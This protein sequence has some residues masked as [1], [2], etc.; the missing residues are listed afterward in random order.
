MTPDESN[1]LLGAI[2]CDHWALSNADIDALHAACL[3]AD[4]TDTAGDDR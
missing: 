4:A 2:R 3:E 1:R